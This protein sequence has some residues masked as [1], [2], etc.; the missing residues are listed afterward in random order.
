MQKF[1]TFASRIQP[2]VEQT[3]DANCS[4]SP[5]IAQEGSTS[6]FDEKGPDIGILHPPPS[7]VINE[8]RE[9]LDN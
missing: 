1:N 5:M 6:C 3:Q 4:P 8:L 9:P 2:Q 7:I